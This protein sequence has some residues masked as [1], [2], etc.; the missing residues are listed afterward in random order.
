MIWISW[1]KKSAKIS[2]DLNEDLIRGM[3]LSRGL[4]DVKVCAVDE[5]W[6]GLKIVV[7]K[8]NR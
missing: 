2:T 6:L 8:E 4:V 7:R 1:Y 3:A 5:K